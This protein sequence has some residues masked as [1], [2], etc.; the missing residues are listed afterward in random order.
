[1]GCEV[2][3]NECI[4]CRHRHSLLSMRI[5][6]VSLSFVPVPHTPKYM[7][8]FCSFLIHVDKGKKCFI[9]FVYGVGN[10]WLRSVPAWLGGHEHHGSVMPTCAASSIS[11]ICRADYI[12]RGLHHLS[13]FFHRSCTL[14]S[15]IHQAL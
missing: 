7:T 5:T 11:V 3:A 15:C 9:Q 6:P 10:D 4:H 1:M 14:T 2:Y 8:I 13:H 12:W